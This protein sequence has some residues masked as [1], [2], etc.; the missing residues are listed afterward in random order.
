[1]KR[2]EFAGIIGFLAIAVLALS[3]AGYLGT[4]TTTQQSFLLPSKLGEA[5]ILIANGTWTAIYYKTNGYDIF[6]DSNYNTVVDWAMNQTR[7]QP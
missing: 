3:Y 7:N 1:M 5:D 4:Q 6:Q 2:K